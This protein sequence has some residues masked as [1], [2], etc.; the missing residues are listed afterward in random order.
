MEGMA[1]NAE[2]ELGVSIRKGNDPVG[3]ITFVSSSHCLTT[4]LIPSQ[5]SNRS[6]VIS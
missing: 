3:W 6:A 1:V 4:L 5:P 2:Y